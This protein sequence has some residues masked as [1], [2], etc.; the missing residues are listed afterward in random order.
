MQDP[1]CVRA[2][3]MTISAV[4]A[5]RIDITAPNVYGV[6]RAVESLS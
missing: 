4:L 2:Y 5:T 3:W 6:I 1:D